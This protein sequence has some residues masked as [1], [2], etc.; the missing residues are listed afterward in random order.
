M[1]RHENLFIGPNSNKCSLSI[2]V[3]S[4]APVHSVYNI[5]YVCCCLSHP[6]SQLKCGPIH[7]WGFNL[8]RP[9]LQ[10]DASR[11]AF[12]SNIEPRSSRMLILEVI[13][14]YCFS[15]YADTVDHSTWSRHQLPH[16]FFFRKIVIIE[17]GEVLIHLRLSL[18]LFS[19]QKTRFASFVQVFPSFVQY[20]TDA[21]L[22]DQA[23]WLPKQQSFLNLY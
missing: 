1:T 10:T 11:Q 3:P 18:F 13:L 19:L 8:P 6:D 21:L 20:T 22:L 12:T 17:A 14:V 16:T 9:N 5:V 2:F 15:P 4:K 23:N 7:L